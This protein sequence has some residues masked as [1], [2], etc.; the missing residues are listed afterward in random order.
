M[1]EQAGD[2]GIEAALDVRGE[3]GAPSDETVDQ[4]KRRK[5]RQAR[6]RTKDYL[7]QMRGGRA[8][9]RRD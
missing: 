7:K 4:A 9:W 5:L 8:L 3:G 1:R 6:A 2:R